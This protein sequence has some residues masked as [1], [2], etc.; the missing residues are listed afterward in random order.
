M[1]HNT[2]FHD[3]LKC[4]PTEL[5]HG[6]TPYNPLDSQFKNPQK[7]VETQCKDL[8]GI[9]DKMNFTFREASDNIISAH[10]KYKT[11]YDRNTRAQPLK[12]HDFVF[13]LDPKNDSQRSKEEFKTFHWKG[14]YKVMKVLSDS[15]HI[16]RKVGAHKTQCVHRM[17]LR[18]LTPGFPIDDTSVS[19]QIYPD[20]ERVEDTDIFHSNISTHD[21]VDQN[22]N[23][24]L[25][26]DLV[27][28]EPSDEKSNWQ[29][30]PR[31]S[32]SQDRT[33]ETPT[34][35]E[36]PPVEIDFND[37]R[38]LN[39]RF[40]RQEEFV[41]PPPRDGSWIRIPLRDEQHEREQ[42]RTQTRT[43][44]EDRMSSRPSRK[45]QSRYGLREN[46]TPKTY[47]DFLIHEITTAQNAL[48]KTNNVNLTI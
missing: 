11:Y 34:R 32:R 20:N 28:N 3:S 42:P 39:V 24:N 19:K 48:R 43:D 23:N 18:L 17:R 27:D 1:A 47:P 30:E 15:N 46:P 8:N 38:P 14:P 37:F 2:T 12:V 22:E 44:V 5:F 25:D 4:S 10:H 35:T 13:L 26:Q 6:R 21:E 45:K 40:G 29:P 36:N 7:Q 33:L 9:L 16:I 31:R 41:L